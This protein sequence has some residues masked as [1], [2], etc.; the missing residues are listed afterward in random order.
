[1]KHVRVTLFLWLPIVVFIVLFYYFLGMPEWVV[2]PLRVLVAPGVVV[3]TILQTSWS[4]LHD[5]DRIVYVI[6]N[7]GFYFALIHIFILV[8]SKVKRSPRMK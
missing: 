5:T 4:E 8:L 6:I 3:V 2:V 7:A 1:M